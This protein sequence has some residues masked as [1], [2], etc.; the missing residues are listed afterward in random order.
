MATVIDLGAQG[1]HPELLTNLVENFN[2]E[3]LRDGEDVS[4]SDIQVLQQRTLYGLSCVNLDGVPWRYEGD[5]IAVDVSV[6]MAV[7]APEGRRKRLAVY[8]AQRFPDR[9]WGI[10]QMSGAWLDDP[11]PRPWAGGFML[12][13]GLGIAWGVLA[14]SGDLGKG[15]FTL[16]GGHVWEDT[17]SNNS[18]LMFVPFNSAELW[19]ST[20]TATIFD[21]QGHEILTESYPLGE[22]YAQRKAPSS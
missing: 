21:S 10:A 6:G 4:E 14:R 22:M 8:K 3:P 17:A 13:R 19:S 2:Q 7:C 9:E 15:R 11:P 1:P 12:D 16:P 18:C 5:V 20:A